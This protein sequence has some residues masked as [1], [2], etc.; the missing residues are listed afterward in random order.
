MS[1]DGSGSQVHVT[2]RPSTAKGQRKSSEPP[3][4]QTEINNETSN[5]IDTNQSSPPASSV[6]Q[7]GLV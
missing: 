3:S 6:T 4:G 1:S 2:D 5:N 7:N